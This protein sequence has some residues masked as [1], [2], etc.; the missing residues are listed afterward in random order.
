MKSTKY[1]AISR[2]TAKGY[3]NHSILLNNS[4]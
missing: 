3:E 4:I 1:G 2:N